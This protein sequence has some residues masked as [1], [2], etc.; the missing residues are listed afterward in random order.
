M[1]MSMTKPCIK[2]PTGECYA[3][4]ARG[5]EDCPY[6]SLTPGLSEATSKPAVIGGDCSGEDGVCESCQ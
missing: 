1:T 2:S 5:D 4:G 6:D 3:C